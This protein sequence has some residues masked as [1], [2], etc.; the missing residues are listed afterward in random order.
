MEVVHGFVLVATFFWLLARRRK[1]RAFAVA[2]SGVRVAGFRGPGSV[3]TDAPSLQA[4]RIMRASFFSVP[5][6]GPR[7]PPR[8]HGR[9]WAYKRRALGSSCRD[10]K[11]RCLT[12]GLMR[13]TD[14][15]RH[16]RISAVL[17]EE[18]GKVRCDGSD[19]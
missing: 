12:A 17:S 2:Y 1:R 18:R 9:G 3:S 15:K 19:C 6:V 16:G 5:S 10:D 13:R 7:W 8:V 4:T 14:C 11:R